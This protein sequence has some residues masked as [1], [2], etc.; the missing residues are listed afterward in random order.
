MAPPTLPA[1]QGQRE[2]GV[3][4]LSRPPPSPPGTVGDDD[5][6]GVGL[7]QRHHGHVQLL[8]DAVGR[9]D[10]EAALQAQ[11]P[12]PSRS[13]Q[14]E[15][16]ASG[17]TGTPPACWGMPST[18]PWCNPTPWAGAAGSVP[19]LPHPRAPKPPSTSP[20][21]GRA[22]AH[23]RGLWPKPTHRGRTRSPGT[24]WA[25]APSWG[26]GTEPPPPCSSPWS[27]RWCFSA[28]SAAPTP[29]RGQK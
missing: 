17:S 22:P 21:Q 16:F 3:G 4:T 15:S 19:A 7:G 29:R 14:D 10:V 27:R 5:A 18:P 13:C 28:S 20:A 26:Q 1:R 12:S 25:P 9:V 24:A 8:G 11:A 6:D 23:S 2:R